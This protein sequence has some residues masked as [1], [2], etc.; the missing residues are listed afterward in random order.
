M[1]VTTYLA[2]V[3]LP[4]RGNVKHWT[5]K[6]FEFIPDEPSLAGS[7]PSNFK[8]GPNLSKTLPVVDLNMGLFSPIVGGLICRIE[9]YPEFRRPRIYRI[10]GAT[11]LQSDNPRWRVLSGKLSKCRIVA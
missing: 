6:R 9:G 7:Q 5:P 10:L 2:Y 8:K 1:G 4:H 3:L 11:D